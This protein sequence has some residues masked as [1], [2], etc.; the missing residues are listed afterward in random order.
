MTLRYAL[1]TYTSSALLSLSSAIQHLSV[2]TMVEKLALILFCLA[3][4]YM[5]LLFFSSVL[6]SS[7]SFLCSILIVT[8]FIVSL[9]K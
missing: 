6:S 9:S 1:E 4:V 5:S 3:Y 8:H 2:S 7:V